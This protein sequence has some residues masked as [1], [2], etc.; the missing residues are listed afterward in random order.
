MMVRSPGWL[1]SS[2]SL[3]QS[4]LQKM[5]CLRDWVLSFDWFLHTPILMSLINPRMREVTESAYRIGTCEVATRSSLQSLRSLAIV[6]WWWW[7]VHSRSDTDS[8]S[9]HASGYMAIYR[10]KS[11]ARWQN[12]AFS[13]PLPPEICCPCE[14]STWVILP[15]TGPCYYISVI[16]RCCYH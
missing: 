14:A 1:T 10:A 7:W 8:W 11:L 3:K 5:E 9:T 16:T 2:L 15:K 6:W 4:T 13:L 12:P